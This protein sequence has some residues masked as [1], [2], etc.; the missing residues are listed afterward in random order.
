MS[1]VVL[2]Y[3]KVLPAMCSA[4]TSELFSIL[5]TPQSLPTLPAPCTYGNQRG[6]TAT[7]RHGVVME[8]DTGA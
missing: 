4:K 2:G 3:L 1:G 6:P 5:P 7:P 8:G